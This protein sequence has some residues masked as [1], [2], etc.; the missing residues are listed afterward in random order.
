MNFRLTALVLLSK[1]QKAVRI[2]IDQKLAVLGLAAWTVIA[3]R[4]R[5]LRCRRDRFAR[6]QVSQFGGFAWDGDSHLRRLVA[7]RLDH[8]RVIVI[9]EQ[10]H[11]GRCIKLDGH[12]PQKILP[13]LRQHLLRKSVEIAGILRNREH[14]QYA[15]GI[16][17]HDQKRRAAA[18]RGSAHHRPRV[19]GLKTNLGNQHL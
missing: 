8:K 18:I 2:D 16:A 6:N 14:V 10:A 3:G 9:V 12:I 17:I 7:I 13:D 15:F 1:G 4:L 19:I 5:G 11:L